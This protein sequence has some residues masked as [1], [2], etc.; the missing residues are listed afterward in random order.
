MPPVAPAPFHRDGQIALATVLL[1]SHLAAKTEI[2]PCGPEETPGD[3]ESGQRHEDCNDEESVHIDIL[4]PRLWLGYTS[5]DVK[6][7][8]EPW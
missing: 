7:D 4:N 1:L 8:K 2:R 6:L 3:D 5:G